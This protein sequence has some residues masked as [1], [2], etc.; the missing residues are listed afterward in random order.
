MKRLSY[1]CSVAV[2][3]LAAQRS[4]SETVSSPDGSGQPF[5]TAR[6]FYSRETATN[7]SPF[8]CL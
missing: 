8:P 4:C 5:E 6:I 2:L 7:G 3:S 1:S